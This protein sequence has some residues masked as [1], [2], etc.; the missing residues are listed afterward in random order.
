[1]GHASVTATANGIA[2]AYLGTPNA[3]GV[4]GAATFSLKNTA[5]AVNLVVTN[6]NETAAADA[7]CI[8]GNCSL[9]QAVNAANANDPGA[10]NH[11]TIT[12]T[13]GLRGR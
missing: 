12:F 5:P 2:G 6:T 8:V 10:G 9:R 13:A 11:N 3:S 1:M 7:T 4:T